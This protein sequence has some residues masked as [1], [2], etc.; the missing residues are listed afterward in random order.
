MYKII[1][2]SLKGNSFLKSEKMHL[3]SITV[4]EVIIDHLISNM[5][6]QH[7]LGR[8]YTHEA[9]PEKETD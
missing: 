1:P 3:P 6:F 2:Q 7:S 8:F 4:I 5:H 9:G